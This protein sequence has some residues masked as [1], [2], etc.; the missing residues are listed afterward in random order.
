MKDKEFDHII[1]QKLEAITDAPPAYM[2]DR[3]ATNIPAPVAKT[4]IST[5]LKVS[6]AAAVLILVSGLTFIISQNA[7][8]IKRSKLENKFSTHTNYTL[9]RLQ[10]SNADSKTVIANAENNNEKKEITTNKAIVVSIKTAHSVKNSAIEHENKEQAQNYN[11]EFDTMFD[12]SQKSTIN[13]SHQK[14]T[15]KK[16]A[17]KPEVKSQETSFD[18]P[19]T[20]EVVVMKENTVGKP[21]VIEPKAENTVI[22]PAEIVES[23]VVAKTVVELK[24]EAEVA[25]QEVEKTVQTSTDSPENIETA[26]ITEVTELQKVTP[27]NRQLNKYGIGIHYGPEFM[28]VGGAKLTDQAFDLSFNY[29]NINFIVQTGIGLRFSQDKVD[30]DMEYKRWDYL[31]TQVRF[32]SVIFVMNPDRTQTLVPVNPYYEEVYDSLSH[33]YHATATE[34]STMLQIPILLGYQFDYKKFAY[35]FKGGIRYSLVIHKL[36]R[37][38]LEIDNQSHLVSL[39]YPKRARASSNIDYEM[40]V[41]GAYKI[42]K[43]LQFHAELFGRYYHYSIYEENPPSGIHPWSVSA[44]IGLVYI[45][46]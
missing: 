15:E 38:L 10:N 25:K 16:T 28:D 7:T 37:D 41:G 14:V 3:I 30:Y 24:Q 11:N 20:V 34:Q 23:Q 26:P 31:E 43:K 44:R 27:K 36:T 17:S 21:E 19:S 5:T 33:S 18:V 39:N 40:S 45:F 12:N 29:Q 32:D 4:S 35:F 9:K 8:T 2:W 6:I 13:A 46:E 22:E 1:K 42:N